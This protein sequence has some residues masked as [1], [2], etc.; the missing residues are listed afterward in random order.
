MTR[1]LDA[2]AAARMNTIFVWARHLFPYILDLPKYPEAAADVPPEQVKANQEQFRWFTRE[3][4][5]RNMRVLL[6]FYNIHVSPP[7][8]GQ[9]WHSAQSQRTDAAAGGLHALRVGPLLSRPSP[10]WGCMS[11][12]GNRWRSSRQLDWFRDVI[13]A[14]AKKSGKNPLIVIR[15][16]THGHESQDPASRTSTRTAIRN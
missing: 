16:W 6:H 7:F 8:A 11:A 5:R 1:T 14:A 9:A 10:R 15:D 12:P 13:F 3:A 2:F 4:R